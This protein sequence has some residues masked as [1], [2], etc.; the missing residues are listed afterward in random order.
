ML[1]K[2]CLFSMVVIIIFFSFTPVTVCADESPASA[3]NNT[4][5]T[6]E[7]DTD[8][9]WDYLYQIQSGDEAVLAEG[10]KP[11]FNFNV[12]SALLME[13]ATGTVLYEY[14]KD[15]K[16]PP[17]S[18]TKIMTLLL[19]MEAIDNKIFTI[20]DSVTAS[21]HACS[22]GGTQIYLEPGETM[23]V[24]ELLKAVAIPSAN[25]AAVALAEFVAGS[26][27]EF[28]RRMNVRASELGMNNTTFANATGFEDP[29]HRTT[30]NDIALMTRELLKHPKIFEYT[31]VWMDTLRNGGFGL[32]NTNKM[33]RTYT[34]MNGMKTGYTD[35]SLYC[36]SGTAERDGMTLIA[37]IMGSPTSN[38]RFAAAGKLL[39]YGFSSYALAKGVPETPA[40]IHVNKGKAP[41][42][43]VTI[44]GGLGM[45]V[46]K[47][48]EKLVETELT[49]ADELQA[50][51]EKGRQVG[52]LTYK[53]SGKVVQTCPILTAEAV[54]KAG[55][56]DYF[57]RLFN[58]MVG[59]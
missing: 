44:D 35:D 57:G 33:L 42:I 41:S 20:E 52:V 22:M 8:A 27:E 21:E 26:E 24:H 7:A 12:K 16:L 11:E 43:A 17:A 15:E 10:A 6:T 59:N 47:G 25:D 19:I 4:E 54:D 29:S 2:M 50:P 39:D 51:I 53:I 45:L 32:A 37:V 34:G 18:V 3:I 23:S 38:D 5:E 48:Q 9:L 1:K 14:Q 36:F 55:F 56:T 28:V 40:P 58:G 13:S 31:T 30:A 49:L 46:P